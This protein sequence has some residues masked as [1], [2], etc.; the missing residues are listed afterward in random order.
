MCIIVDCEKF[1]IFLFDYCFI[2]KSIGRLFKNYNCHI[3]WSLIYGRCAIWILIYW[4]HEMSK[5]SGTEYIIQNIENQ[6]HIF[7]T[8][9]YLDN[10]WMNFDL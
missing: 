3:L 9:D 2:E 1:I 8:K 7:V 4:L 5:L 6:P 10:S